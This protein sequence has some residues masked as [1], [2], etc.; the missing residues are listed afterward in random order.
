MP[1]KRGNGE[2]AVY[3]RS[4][5]KRWFG[6]LSV[7]FDSSGRTIRKTVSAKTRTE[8]VR[9]LRDLQLTIDQGILAP[10]TAVTVKQL[11]ERWGSDVLMFQVSEQTR[12]NYLTVARMHIL[13]DLGRV[14]V[15]DLTTQQID[16]LLAMKLRSGLS[17]STVRRIRSVLAQALDQAV[18]WG[19]TPRNVGS[20]S[21]A[22]RNSRKEG[23]TL[24]PAQA[25]TLLRSLSGHRLECLFTLMLA[26]G[27]RRGEALGLRWSDVDLDRA[28]IQVRRQLIR[29]SAGLMLSDT[30]TPRSR[31]AVNVPKQLV[32]TLRAHRDAQDIDRDLAGAA[33]TETGFLFT[34]QLGTPLDPR[35]LL[36]DFKKV[37]EGA[38]LGDWHVHELRHSAASLMLAQGV[39]LQ[40]VSEVLG[41]ASVRMTAD[42]YGHILDPDRV[43]AAEAMGSILWST[44][45]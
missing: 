21:R 1:G 32:E 36:R 44:S 9:K 27:L 43:A 14:R 33:W 12:S 13:P 7:G 28:I 42:V 11:F 18:R 17:I 25:T 5:D 39:K 24:T 16:R 26:T 45:S 23:R 2:G 3:Q 15:L 8:A 22:P 6:A 41:H 4:S 29:T 38:G 34:T 35:N 37:C 30:K 40:V 10:D 19:W 20:L 31:R